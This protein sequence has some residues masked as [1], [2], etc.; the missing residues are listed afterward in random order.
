MA[1]TSIQN[2]P[3]TKKKYYEP[4]SLDLTLRNG[5]GGDLIDGQEVF[6]SAA[7]TVNKRTGGAQYPV[8]TVKIGGEN[9]KL[10]TVATSFVCDMKGIATGG[11][12]ATGAFVRQNGTLNAEALP[13]YVV[14]AAG[15]F[16]TGV[17]IAG[18]NSGLEIRVGV[19]RVP[20]IAA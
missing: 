6:L 18:A 15:E 14:A 4:H 2:A 19:L 5:S 17:V 9:G 11:N 10:V 16:A 20:F 1:T 8:G 13:Q 12:I 3:K 7:N